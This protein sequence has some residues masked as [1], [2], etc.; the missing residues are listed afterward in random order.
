MTTP[1][2]T[3]AELYLDELSRLLAPTEPVDR[4]EILTGVREHIESRMADLPS[5]SEA[6]MAA[7]LRG[8]GSPDA[9]ARQ[10]LLD[11]A[12]VILTDP[13]PPPTPLFARRGIPVA[14]AILLSLSLASSIL[15]GAGLTAFTV[16]T[17]ATFGDGSLVLGPLLP[18]VGP[19][20]AA[21]APISMMLPFWL[22]ALLLLWPSPLWNPTWKVVGTALP[23]IPWV[24]IPLAALSLDAGRASFVL[25]ALASLVLLILSMRATRDSFG[26]GASLVVG[27][28]PS[29]GSAPAPA[30]SP[31]AG[32]WVPFVV[33]LLLGLTVLL[34]SLGISGAATD[35]RDTAGYLAQE[36]AAALVGTSLALVIPAWLPALTLLWASPLWTWPWRALGSVAPLLPI[37]G[38]LLAFAT[39]T[40]GL[41]GNLVGL[42]C[43][44]IIVIGVTRTSHMPTH[45]R[46][47]PDGI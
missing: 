2:P 21:V 19:A 34:G 27:T 32:N 4:I 13:A 6:D 17:T 20:L 1:L 30:A 15:V 22:P 3:Q 46:D 33:A 40:L 41:P 39:P 5:P 11:A 23:A 37:A 45:G 24:G 28:A 47:T 31:F 38:G 44:A 29:A 9:V 18:Q 7:I 42:L 36:R 35:A 8:L 43:A 16:G 25:G 10:A 26:R 12:P 14:V